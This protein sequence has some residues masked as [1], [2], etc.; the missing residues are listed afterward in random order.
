MSAVHISEPGG[1]HRPPLA[2]AYTPMLMHNPNARRTVTR[3]APGLRHAL[4]IRD[5]TLDFGF[6]P[7]GGPITPLPRSTLGAQCGG[8]ELFRFPFPC[9]AHHFVQ[10]RLSAQVS[11]LQQVVG[12]AAF[13]DMELYDLVLDGVASHQPVNGRER[14]Q[15][16]RGQSRKGVRARMALKIS[17]PAFQPPTLP[18]DSTL[19][20]R[21]PAF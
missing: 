21:I 20:F 8:V 16:E 13:V 12:E 6:L 17:L 10:R 7:A 4:K 14:G 15:R 19:F 9:Q 3:I 18:A 2:L 5:S 11:A 1:A